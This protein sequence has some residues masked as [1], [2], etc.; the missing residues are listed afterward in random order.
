[1]DI[2]GD[3]EMRRRA[4][5]RVR[6]YYLITGTVAVAGLVF[7]GV[8]LARVGSRPV[9]P[10]LVLGGIAL[11]T[12][13]LI[14]LMVRTVRRRTGSWVS[15]MLGA[16]RHTRRRVTRAIRTGAALPPDEQRLAVAEAT[17][18]R[19]ITGILTIPFVFAAVLNLIQFAG[20]LADG[21]A[22]WRIVASGAAA[23]AFTLLPL[24]QLFYYRRAGAYLA[25]VEHAS[26]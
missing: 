2:Q 3:H 22:A 1:M 5:R 8:V 19:K 18:I 26:S 25:G 6:V 9:V 17:R 20:H 13:G 10:L 15:P 7:I 11:L 12:A 14:A 16:D 21:S 23:A 24:Y 4:T